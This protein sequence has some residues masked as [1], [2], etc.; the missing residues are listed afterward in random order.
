MTR[1]AGRIYHCG[2]GNV[3]ACSAGRVYHRGRGQILTSS[4]GSIYNRGRACNGGR[5]RRC[6]CN[7]ERD[8]LSYWRKGDLFGAHAGGGESEIFCTIA[9][10]AGIARSV[11]ISSLRLPTLGYICMRNNVECLSALLP[12]RKDG[13]G[14]RRRQA[15]WGDGTVFVR[16]L[17]RK[18]AR[19][20]ARV[21]AC[22]HSRAH[23]GLNGI[24]SP[25]GSKGLVVDS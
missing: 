15:T 5:G 6:F 18:L 25:R 16:R 12:C 13:D 22:G 1:G 10:C 19:S 2:R 23:P 8:R 11:S 17:I 20:S 21:R 14:A 9:T 24:V 7:S 4:A 3:V